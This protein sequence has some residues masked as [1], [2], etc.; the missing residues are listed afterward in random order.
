MQGG[1][2]WGGRGG[3]SQPIST[4]V[5]GSPNKLWKSSYLLYLTYARYKLMV[6]LLSP[7]AAICKDELPDL[8]T[9]FFLN[10]L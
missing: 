4:P 5:H 10:S 7:L 8:L 6:I 1:G 2:S 3:G 9:F